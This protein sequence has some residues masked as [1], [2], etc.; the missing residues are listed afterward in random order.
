MGRASAGDR[1]HLTTTDS[2]R[3]T[4]AIS[5]RLDIRK[6]LDKLQGDYLVVTT[7]SNLYAAGGKEFSHQTRLAAE[8]CH[9]IWIKKL[10]P[11]RPAACSVIAGPFDCCLRR[12]SL[13]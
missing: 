12:P 1:Q 6:A 9:E 5:R 10:E 11:I 7:P 2:S 3:S 4:R 13:I 8:R